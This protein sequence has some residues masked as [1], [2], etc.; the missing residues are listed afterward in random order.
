[1]RNIV[2][3]L[4]CED[5]QADGRHDSARNAPFLIRDIY[6]TFKVIILKSLTS[7][8]HADEKVLLYQSARYSTPFSC[9][10]N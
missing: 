1:M 7:Q 10:W 3:V 8:E 6:T 5:R 2:L 9:S 4:V